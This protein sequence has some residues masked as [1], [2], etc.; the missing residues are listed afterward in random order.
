MN[1]YQPNKVYRNAFYWAKGG[2]HIWTIVR[3]K[4]GV[5]TQARDHT[6][7]EIKVDPASFVLIGDTVSGAP[8]V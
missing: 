8:A 1:A 7:P 5:W 4:N 3:H 2:K 6:S